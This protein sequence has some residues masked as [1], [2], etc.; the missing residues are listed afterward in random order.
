M[1]RGPLK[2]T[3]NASRAQGHW[4]LESLSLQKSHFLQTSWIEQT[5]PDRFGQPDSAARADFAHV[6]D[7]SAG[8]FKERA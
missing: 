4:V 3:F 7:A 5:T 6:G 1:K 2:Q 8:C